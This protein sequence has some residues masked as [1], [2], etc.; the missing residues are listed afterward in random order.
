MHFLFKYK[1]RSLSFV[2]L[3]WRNLIGNPF[4]YSN[5]TETDST[6]SSFSS[7]TSTTSTGTVV[8]NFNALK[9]K[10]NQTHSVSQTSLQ[11]SSGITTAAS[12]KQCPPSIENSN[13][14]HLLQCSYA[15]LMP[16]S[17][18]KDQQMSNT[19]SATSN[20]HG[21]IKFR[22]TPNFHCE[23]FWCRLI[24]LNEC[25]F[26]KTIRFSVIFFILTRFSKLCNQCW[27]ERKKTD[28]RQSI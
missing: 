24:E 26:V 16:N 11:S 18:H 9:P 19:S 28:K 2:K 7:A 14:C 12:T 13:K 1:F 3:N 8:C 4:K 5:I 22:T 15:N 27:L 6:E 17:S 25:S 20:N 10:N 23:S 21:T